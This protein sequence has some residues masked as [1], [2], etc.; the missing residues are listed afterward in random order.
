MDIDVAVIDAAARNE[1]LSGVVAVDVG[2]E[3]V[4][5]RCFGYAH[6][7]LGI[8]VTRKTR[9]AFAS[10]SKIMTALA[11]LRLVESGALR[12]SDPVRPILGDDLPLIDDGVTIEHLV[13]HTSGIGDYLDE[14]ADWE[15]SDYVLPV[16]VHTLDRTE[17][18]VPVIDGFAQISAPGERFSY[19]N[20]GYIVLALVIDRLSDVG[21]HT[22][23]EQEVCSRVGLAGMAYLRSDELPGDAALGY[24]FD[25]GDRSNVLHLPVRGNGDGGIYSTVDDLHSFWQAFHAG[26]IVAPELVQIMITPRHDVPAEGLRYGLGCWLHPTAAAVL[27]EGYDA[28][29]SMRSVHDPATRTTATVLANSSEGAWGVAGELLNLFD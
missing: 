1:R 29:V 11:V 5:E 8:P 13:G 14:E 25:D 15:A 23:V 22:Y 16:A 6:R 20:G 2:D 19:N 28:G 10:G 27:V 3:R 21:F 26:Q 18:F 17:A 4:L 12:L 24:L 7:A 9:F